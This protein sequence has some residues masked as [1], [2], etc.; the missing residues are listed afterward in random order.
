M[1][2]GT[3]LLLH[4]ALVNGM[5]ETHA[6]TLA[7]TTFVLFQFFNVFNARVGRRSAISRAA[8]RNPHL[9][10]A[11]GAVLA[12]QVLAVHW[13]PAQRIFHTTALSGTDWAA[14][15]VVASTVILLDESRKLLQ[16]LT[17]RRRRGR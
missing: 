1:A 2:V 16:R 3:L 8:L 15:A 5:S 14:A 6:R 9:M 13:P 17:R 4:W 10:A 7:F 11:L 12:L